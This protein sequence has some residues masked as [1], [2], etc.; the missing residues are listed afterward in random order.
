MF[1]NKD[2]IRISGIFINWISYVKYHVFPNNIIFSTFGT[3][4]TTLFY[5][6][7]VHN[8]LAINFV[9]FLL[10]IFSRSGS[11]IF[12]DINSCRNSRVEESYKYFL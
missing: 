4:R 10:Y 2:K 5:I 6:V 12:N 1:E 8:L 11:M 3:Y 7:E 9:S